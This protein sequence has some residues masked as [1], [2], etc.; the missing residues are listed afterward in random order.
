MTL[1]SDSGTSR[2]FDVL[3]SVK[4]MK[5]LCESLQLQMERCFLGP[6]ME[7][8]ACGDAELTLATLLM[9]ACLRWELARYVCR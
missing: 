5:M 6:M 7:A 1:L 3:K 8:S 9:E 2:P 4:G